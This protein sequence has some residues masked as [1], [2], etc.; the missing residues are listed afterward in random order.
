[1]SHKN[2]RSEPSSDSDMCLKALLRVASPGTTE[3][4]ERKEQ[5][6]KVREARATLELDFYTR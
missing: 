2:G 5:M 3:R 6:Q 1:M 4:T